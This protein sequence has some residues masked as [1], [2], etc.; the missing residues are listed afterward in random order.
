MGTGASVLLVSQ[1]ELYKVM[2]VSRL[3]AHFNIH[4]EH[5]FL[6]QINELLQAQKAA[7]KEVYDLLRYFVFSCLADFAINQSV[8]LHYHE[9]TFH[10]R[11]LQLITC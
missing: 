1:N 10:G 5:F 9:M 11:N 4:R 7:T 2:Y 8:T 3:T 6:L